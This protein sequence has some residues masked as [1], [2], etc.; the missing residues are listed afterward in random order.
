MMTFDAERSR[1]SIGKTRFVPREERARA[2]DW[3]R[4]ADHISPQPQRL[5]SEAE[6]MPAPERFAE[7]SDSFPLHRG[8]RPYMAQTRCAHSLEQCRMMEVEQTSCE[9]MKQR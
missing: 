2:C 4:S 5:L 3:D 9:R 7:A 1:P 6:C 8:R